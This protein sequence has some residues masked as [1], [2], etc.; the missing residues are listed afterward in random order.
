MKQT[1][2]IGTE[3]VD[4]TDCTKYHLD[5]QTK[6]HTVLLT[7]WEDFNAGTDQTTFK[8]TQTLPNP[9]LFNRKVSKQI[10]EHFFHVLL[11]LFTVCQLDTWHYCIQC[12][13]A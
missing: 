1:T 9:P 7:N 6:H 2:G 8:G 13:A 5:H 11:V 10:C 12:A 3:Y 4:A